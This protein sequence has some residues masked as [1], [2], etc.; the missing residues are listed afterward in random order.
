MWEVGCKMNNLFRAKTTK[1]ENENHGFNNVWVYGDLLTNKGAHYIHPQNNVFRLDGE[2]AKILIAHEVLS[3]T[4]GRFFGL[5]DKNGAKIFEG[6][7][8]KYKLKERINDVY[9]YGYVVY[10]QDTCE[11]VVSSIVEEFII[12]DKD[13]FNDIEDIEIIGNIHDNPEFLEK[14]K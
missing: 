14:F 10:N 3:E 2:L 1:K 7:F 8:L 5:T 12:P 6:D 13:F 9:I 4:I 11:F